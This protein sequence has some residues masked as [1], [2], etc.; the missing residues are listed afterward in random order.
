MNMLIDEI[1]PD[2]E[3]D[4]G[5]FCN[6]DNDFDDYHI[7]CK[8][9]PLRIIINKDKPVILNNYS[10][11]YLTI[12]NKLGLLQGVVI[13]GTC[14]SGIVLCYKIIHKGIDR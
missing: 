1:H 14:I 12:R 9:D 3:E 4:Y 8:K 6:L 13:F 10:N 7:K 5:F 11:D 2:L